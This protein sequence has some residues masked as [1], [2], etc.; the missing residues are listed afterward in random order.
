[1]SCV[2]PAAPEP[3][4]SGSKQLSD[5][6]DKIWQVERLEQGADITREIVDGVD[7]AARIMDDRQRGIVFP[8]AVNELSAAHAG[9]AAVV[10]TRSK[11]SADLPTRPQAARPSQAFT[12][13]NP[14]SLSIRAK[15]L[16][17]CRLVYYQDPGRQSVFP[18]QRRLTTKRSGSSTA[19]GNAAQPHRG[20]GFSG[21]TVGSL[22]PG[23]DDRGSGRQRDEA[24]Y[25]TLVRV[26]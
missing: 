12:T 18:G 8:E 22:G 17:W 2:H 25:N 13:S 20:T 16:A 10:T 24:H 9:H 6:G 21:D 1:M 7:V 14:S 3:P 4:P 15:Q 11:E 26:A 19:C 23:G 5:G